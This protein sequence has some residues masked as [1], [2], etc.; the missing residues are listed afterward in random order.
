MAPK[1][2]VRRLGRNR[3]VVDVNNIPNLL[4]SLPAVYQGAV[5][6]GSKQFENDMR[7]YAS[8][9]EWVPNAP[10][11]VE[12]K[13][14]ADPM[15]GR[16][17]S[18]L[19]GIETRASTDEMPAPPPS[20]GAQRLVGWFGDQMHPDPSFAGRQFT[21]AEIGW[22]HELGVEK[23]GSVLPGD[24]GGSYWDIPP[25]PWPSAVADRKGDE[26]LVAMALA[27]LEG[28]FAFNNIVIT[29]SDGQ[30]HPRTKTMK[31]NLK[32]RRA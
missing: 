1:P 25:R 7:A 10:G 22:I 19:A 15:I 28:I 24:T 20:A 14:H 16:T 12:W 13:G 18:L 26:A 9:N 11:T 27:A 4:S 2:T 6:V 17:G 23:G 32:G 21:L 3:S 30:Y 5:E 8:A 31:L 29:G